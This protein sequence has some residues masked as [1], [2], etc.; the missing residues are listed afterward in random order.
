MGYGSTLWGW[1]SDGEVVYVAGFDRQYR[2]YVGSDP[3]FSYDTWAFAPSKDNGFAAQVGREI[4][5]T[6]MGK[7]SDND[8]RPFAYQDGIVYVVEGD[9]IV[10]YD[11]VSGARKIL[12]GGVAKDSKAALSD[13][14]KTVI[15]VSKNRDPRVGTD[16]NQLFTVL[17][18]GG[19]SKQI[20]FESTGVEQPSF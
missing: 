10:S 16:A 4:H 17:T 18:S 5:T 11:E 1:R 13:D 14:G 7:I 3:L 8:G 12:A 2:M 9:A 6:S 20:T 19:S 15:Y